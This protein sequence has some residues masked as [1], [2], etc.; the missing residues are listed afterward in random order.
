MMKVDEIDIGMKN[1]WNVAFNSIGSIAVVV[2]L[3]N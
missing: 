2:E 1:C 3:F